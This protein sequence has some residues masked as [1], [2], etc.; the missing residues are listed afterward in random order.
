MP[1]GGKLAFFPWLTLPEPVLVGGFRFVP[2][3]ANDPGSQVGK[4][5]AETTKLILSR[6]VDIQGKP[7]QTCTVAL[8]PRHPRAWDIPESL[9][10]NLFRASECLALVAMAEQRFFEQLSPHINATLFRPIVQGVVPGQNGLAL[11]VKRRDGGLRAGGLKF[12]NVQFQMPLEAYHTECPMPSRSFVKSLNAARTSRLEAWAAIEQ[13]L[14]FFLLGHSEATATPDETC[15]L[16]S[17]LAFERLLSSGGTKLKNANDVSKAFGKLW[18][19]FSTRKVADAKR[20]AVDPEPGY[21]PQ[22][23]D[24]PIHRKWMKELYEARSE[25]A[26]GTKNASRSSNWTP[27]QHVLLAAFTYPLSVK[28]LLATEHG[29]QLTAKEKGACMA[30]DELLDGHWGSGWKRPA[31][32]PSILSMSESSSEWI[33]I[34]ER[35]IGDV[36]G[37]SVAANGSP[38]KDA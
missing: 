7:I 12:E 29:Y 4:E 15:V 5:I 30:L 2:I 22:Q 17:A 14:P 9:W 23:K 32:W 10:P 31:E 6:Y 11:F 37:K 21:G 27:G 24:W 25:Q 26:H 33:D 3:K 13:S 36:Y 18:N 28:L 1:T 20:V 38:D 34:C 8:R 16:L 19:Q 35:A